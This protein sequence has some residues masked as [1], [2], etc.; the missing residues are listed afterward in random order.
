[1]SP[2]CLFLPVQ[3]GITPA[4]CLKFTSL[5]GVRRGSDPRPGEERESSDT[6]VPSLSFVRRDSESF[7]VSPFCPE[8]EPP[9]S[10]STVPEPSKR[11]PL[12][13]RL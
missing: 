12:V 1:M 2:G 4:R 13:H 6:F 11:T 7:R 5:P 10:S 9:D 3:T 8:C